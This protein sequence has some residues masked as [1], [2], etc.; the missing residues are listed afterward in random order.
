MRSPEM[1]WREAKKLL[2]KDHRYAL[3]Q[4][5]P[6]EDRGRYV[7]SRSHNVTLAPYKPAQTNQVDISL[8]FVNR[9]K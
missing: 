5:L 6:K 4:P 7:L 2:K 1:V 3:A 9:F 8:L